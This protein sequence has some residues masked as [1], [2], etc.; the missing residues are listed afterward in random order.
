M[1]TSRRRLSEDEE[2]DEISSNSDSGSEVTTDSTDYN[3]DSG[4]PSDEDS[5]QPAAPVYDGT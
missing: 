2:I 5:S 4:D 1:A 3:S